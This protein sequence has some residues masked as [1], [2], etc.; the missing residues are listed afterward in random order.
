[1]SIK[2]NLEA[3]LSTIS[4]NNTLIAVSKGQ[5]I[6]SLV[7]VYDCGIRLF[8]ENRHKELIEKHKELPADISWH[9]IGSLQRS[10]VKYVVPIATL[11]HSVDSERLL[12]TINK[13]AAK[14]SKIMDVLFEVHVAQEQSKSGWKEQDLIDFMESGRCDTLTNIRVRGI[15]AM[16]SNTGDDNKIKEEFIAIKELF[17]SLKDRCF[18]GKTSFDTI[19]AGMSN[20]Y[21]IALECGANM[22][23]VGSSIFK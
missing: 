12:E 13:E 5:P 15:M 4:S 1:M 14:A 9:F 8:G 18:K 23:R 16:A 2:Q 10:N 20:D 7:E 22:V 6:T 17:D 21:M 19:S 11:I 3:I